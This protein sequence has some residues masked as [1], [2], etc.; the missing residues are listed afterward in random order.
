MVLGVRISIDE[1][2]AEG[3][4][5]DEVA[6][7]C[8]AMERTGQVDYFNLTDGSATTLGAAVML[9]LAVVLAG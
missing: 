5:A 8:E 2:N 3:L 1:R 4:T 9:P 7:V 6:E